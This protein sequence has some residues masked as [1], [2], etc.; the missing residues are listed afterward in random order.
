MTEL[1]Y[2]GLKVALIGM[3]VTFV[4]LVALIGLIHLNRFIAESV[5]K[6]SHTKKEPASTPKAHPS[7]IKH[8]ATPASASKAAS[9]ADETGVIAAITAAVTLC[10]DGVPFK[11]KSVTKA[12]VSGAVNAWDMVA[13]QEQNNNF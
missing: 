9:K 7:Q 6:A 10:M 2:F 12:K 3:G 4:G 11:V 8:P 13:I 1:I 5:N